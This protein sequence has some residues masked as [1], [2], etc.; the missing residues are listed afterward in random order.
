LERIIDSTTALCK[1]RDKSL[2]T[3]DREDRGVV[4]VIGKLSLALPDLALA[5][6]NLIGG[7]GVAS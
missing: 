5:S 2:L 4:A 1:A 3:N 6:L 7:R